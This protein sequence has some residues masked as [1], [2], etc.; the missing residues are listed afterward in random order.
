[1]TRL[2]AESHAIKYLGESG[3]VVS[4]YF[5]GVVHKEL[6]EVKTLLLS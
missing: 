5:A 3:D 4:K 6:R 2:G 1:M